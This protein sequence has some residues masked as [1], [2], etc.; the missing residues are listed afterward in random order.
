MAPFLGLVEGVYGTRST[1]QPRDVL[2]ASI[3]RHGPSHSVVV[4]VPT[5]PGA[6][7]TPSGVQGGV[8]Q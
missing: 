6:E 2:K 4:V 3:S 8:Q 5:G 7:A 1:P